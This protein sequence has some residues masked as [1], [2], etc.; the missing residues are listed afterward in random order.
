MAKV[1]DFAEMK[2]EPQLTKENK[3]HFLQTHS[4]NLQ[5]TFYSPVTHSQLVNFTNNNN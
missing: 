1:E 2:K 3:Q 4:Q 5:H